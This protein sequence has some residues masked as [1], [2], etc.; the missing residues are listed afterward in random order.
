MIRSLIDYNI[1]FFTHSLSQKVEDIQNNSFTSLCWYDQR[2]NLQLQFYGQT[3][4]ADPIT[5]SNY[6]KMVQNFRDYKGPKPGTPF[7][8]SIDNEI[9]FVV[10]K[11]E[12]DELVALRIG[13][14]NHQKT[15][16][17]FRNGEAVR[18][19]LVPQLIF[20]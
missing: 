3:R 16:F 2:Q 17:V 9:H 6:K 20:R 13:R 10:L 14:E 4:I 19:E 7:G 12:L 8:T 5:T 11:M 18:T 15:K 1:F